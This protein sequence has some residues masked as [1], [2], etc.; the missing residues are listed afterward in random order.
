[1]DINPTPP[2]P[3]VQDFQKSKPLGIPSIAREQ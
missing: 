2:M 1:M 3:P